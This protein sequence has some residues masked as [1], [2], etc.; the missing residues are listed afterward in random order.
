M[1]CFE[2]CQGSHIFEIPIYAFS[3]EIFRKRWNAKESRDI[4]KLIKKGFNAEMAKQLVQRATE[5]SSIWHYNRMVG[6]LLLTTKKEN[7]LFCHLYCNVKP[8]RSITH[9]TDLPFINRFLIDEK[10]YLNNLESDLELIQKIKEKIE[11]LKFQYGIMNYYFD[12]TA[13]EN[14]ISLKKIQES[15]SRNLGEG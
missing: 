13:L 9:H 12:C 8:P 11:Y 3:K 6:I 4:N 1:N 7:C 2:E 5:Y 10:I 14:C 15:I